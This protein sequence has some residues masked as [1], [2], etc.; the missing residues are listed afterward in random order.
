MYVGGGI[1]LGDGQLLTT[2]GRPRGVYLGGAFIKNTWQIPGR[3]FGRGV[4]SNKY[5]TCKTSV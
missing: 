1:Y 5:G 2:H 3:L 4:Y